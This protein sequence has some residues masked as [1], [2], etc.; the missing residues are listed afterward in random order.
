MFAR[1]GCAVLPTR[2][3]EESSTEWVGW[4]SHAMTGDIVMWSG[5]CD[6]R[7]LPLAGFNFAGVS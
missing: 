2:L 3:M 7:C 5:V 1:V 4:V 6:I